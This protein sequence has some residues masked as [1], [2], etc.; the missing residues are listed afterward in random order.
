MLRVRLPSGLRAA[1]LDALVDD[2]PAV[3]TRDGDDAL[4]TLTSAAGVP[5]RWAVTD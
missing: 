2:V 3:V 4:V 5:V 1:T